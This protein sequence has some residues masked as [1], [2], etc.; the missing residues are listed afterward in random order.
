MRS[1]LCCQVTPGSKAAIANLCIGDIITA[2]DGEDT[3]SMTHLEAQNKI[4]GCTDNMTLTVSRWG[5]GSVSSFPMD[6]KLFVDSVCLPHLRSPGASPAL[7][8]A[9]WKHSGR[10]VASDLEVARFF[11]DCHRTSHHL[12]LFL[13]S[14]HIFTWSGTT[15]DNPEEVK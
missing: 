13:L 10:P 3:S 9:W 12:G 6:R 7:C 8:C 14:Y 1:P 15:I 2:I 4:K 5:C 11:S